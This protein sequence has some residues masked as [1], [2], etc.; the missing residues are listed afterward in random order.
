VCP[1]REPKIARTSGLG[2][3]LEDEIEIQFEEMRGESLIPVPTFQL[4]LL[5]AS[6]MTT[7]APKD[8]TLADRNPQVKGE[9]K[10]ETKSPQ[11]RAEAPRLMSSSTPALTRQARFVRW[12]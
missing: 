7:A 11:P 1:G 4:F 2:F 3:E 9:K 10:I 8:S 5:H 12:H 6:L